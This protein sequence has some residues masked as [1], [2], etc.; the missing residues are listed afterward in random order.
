M[1]QRENGLIGGGSCALARLDGVGFCLFWAG[2]KEEKSKWQVNKRRC[3]EPTNFF[4]KRGICHGINGWSSKRYACKQ[5]KTKDNSLMP[6][7]LELI[8]RRF[9]LCARRASLDP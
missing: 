1:S 6:L 3:Y 8:V 2:G 7:T 9:S 4:T 5:T